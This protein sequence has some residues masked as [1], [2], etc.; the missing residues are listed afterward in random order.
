MSHTTLLTKGSYIIAPHKVLH[1]RLKFL[2]LVII[3]I[4]SDYLR[5]LLIFLWTTP[6]LFTH[7]FVICYKNNNYQL[8]LTG[9]INYY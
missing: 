5:S 8:K 1:D 9:D 3:L 7:M 2:N 6:C 4:L